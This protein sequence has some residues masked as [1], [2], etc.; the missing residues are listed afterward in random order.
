VALSDSCKD[1]Y[2]SGTSVWT[3]DIQRDI[4]QSNT[5]GGELSLPPKTKQN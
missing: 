2:P 3:T 5:D 1:S 4:T